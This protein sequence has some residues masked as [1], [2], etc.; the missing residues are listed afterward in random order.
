M[1]HVGIWKR[2]KHFKLFIMFLKPL[3]NNVCSLAWSIFLLKEPTAIRKYHRHEGVYLFSN[4][5]KLLGPVPTPVPIVDT[6]DVNRGHHGQSDRS[7]AT[8]PHTHQVTFWRFG[9]DGIAL[10][11]RRLIEPRT[12]NTLSLV[13][14]LSLS[15][16]DWEHPTSLAVSGTLS[17]QSFS[18][19]KVTQLFTHVHFSCI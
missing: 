10:T 11:A 14:G 18:H 13:C 15:P 1:C 19:N 2:W 7:A 12:S 4:N 5:V 17:P 3:S 6:F 16:A 8:R 9:S